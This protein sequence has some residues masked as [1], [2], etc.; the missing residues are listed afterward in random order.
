[1]CMCVCV[2]VCVCV[3]ATCVCV[4]LCVCVC[5]YVRMCS[6]YT[7]F[8]YFCV[9]ETLGSGQCQAVF[10]IVRRCCEAERGP[11][12]SISAMPHFCSSEFSIA[13]C[14]SRGATVPFRAHACQIIFIFTRNEVKP[15][16]RRRSQGTP[17]FLS[18]RS[19]DQRN[20]FFRSNVRNI[21]VEMYQFVSVFFIMAV[22]V[23]GGGRGEQSVTEPI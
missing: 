10:L 9:A 1:M 22:V 23:L 16:T 18:A 20:E 15:P 8:V 17:R 3:C 21:I 7:A 14:I 19:I 6:V 5:V 12:A 4:C 2:C 13:L 11:A